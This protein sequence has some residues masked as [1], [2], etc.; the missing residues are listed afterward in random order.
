MEEVVIETEASAG[1]EMSGNFFPTAV[2]EE[3]L[4]EAREKSLQRVFGSS[5][6]ILAVDGKSNKPNQCSY[7]DIVRDKMTQ[8]YEKGLLCLSQEEWENAVISF[9]K[10][11]NLCP[12]KGQSLFQQ[13]RYMEALECF[14]R[15]S[16][17]QPQNRHYRMRS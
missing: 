11:I 9:S 4:Q 17:L 14:T 12:E 6:A 8:H 16:E 10:A 1:E 7:E 3:K 13:M 5:R 15:A 2:S